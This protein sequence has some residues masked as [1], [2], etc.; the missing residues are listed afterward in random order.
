MEIFDR[1]KNATA[2]HGD[3]SRVLDGIENGLLGGSTGLRSPTL[4]LD[5]RGSGWRLG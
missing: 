4:K 3:A 1:V 2:D 5:G